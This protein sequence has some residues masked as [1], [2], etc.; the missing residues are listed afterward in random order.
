VDTPPSVTSALAKALAA[1]GMEGP[2]VEPLAARAQGLCP[3]CRPGARGQ[4]NPVRQGV[5][6]PVWHMCRQGRSAAWR[7]GFR[8]WPSSSASIALHV[9]QEINPDR[10][11]VRPITGG[12]QD[13]RAGQALVREQ[14]RPRGT[15]PCLH[16]A[17]TSAATP[18]S[19]RN[20]VSSP[21]SVSGTSAGR[22]STTFK[23]E[24]PGDAIGGVGRAD[25][26]DGGAAGRHHQRAGAVCGPTWN[27]PSA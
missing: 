18:E 13:G 11:A 10:L 25:L 4:A 19:S 21:P 16:C 17:V 7:A 26:G 27:R 15:R 6:Q 23:P 8:A 3:A 2:A 22:G 9:G 20:R 12:L 24:L 14:E 5:S 1:I